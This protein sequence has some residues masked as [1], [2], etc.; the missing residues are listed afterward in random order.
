MRYVSTFLLL[1]IL[2]ALSLR[3]AGQ[4]WI[5]AQFNDWS[6]ITMSIW[7]QAVPFLLMG[8]ALAAA[9]TVFPLR[10]AITA[11]SNRPLLDVPAAAGLGSMLPTC[12]CAS[13]PAARS[14]SDGGMRPAAAIAFMVA[15]P[16]ANII[17]IVSTAVAF[18]S[19][20]EMAY[21]RFLA[22]ILTAVTIGVAW[23]WIGRGIGGSI[24]PGR[25][26]RRGPRTPKASAKV[27]WVRFGQ[28][29][30][31]EFISA[32]SLL[33]IGA[34][35]A[36]LMK[37]VVPD[38]LP[39]FQH[40]LG[41]ILAAVLLAVILSLCSEADAFVAA[42]LSLSPVGQLVFMVVGPVVDIKLMIL[43]G[44][45]FGSRF[46]L[47]FVPLALVASVASAVAVSGVIL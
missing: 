29:M 1:G 21:A 47:R 30:G 36:G 8:T 12:E 34:G 16:S 10:G 39:F 6:V 23:H 40:P 25:T 38:D 27:S 33:V 13:V 32:A 3:P 28:V 44:G 15:A 37:T 17:V 26:L 43:Q 19:Q 9:I 41:S 7:I 18:S 24:D 42:S 11:L 2:A 14:L 45:A 46:L 5:P 22:A 4:A 31:R 20:I 35:L